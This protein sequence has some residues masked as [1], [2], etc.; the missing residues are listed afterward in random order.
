M[1][2]QHAELLGRQADQHF[3]DE[4]CV[5]VAQGN[6]G[7]QVQRELVFLERRVD[8]AEHLLFAR[9]RGEIPGEF[10]VLAVTLET[11]RRDDRRIARNR[12]GGE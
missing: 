7:L 2:A 4:R 8:D 1:R 12:V 3:D 10:V 9:Q 6:D 5:V 11:K